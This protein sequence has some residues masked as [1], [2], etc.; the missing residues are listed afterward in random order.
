MK[1]QKYNSN[2]TSENV[3]VMRWDSTTVKITG[4]I[5]YNGDVYRTE[6]IETLFN[7]FADNINDVSSDDTTLQ[8]YLDKLIKT[9]NNIGIYRMLEGFKYDE[10]R[11]YNGKMVLLQTKKINTSYTVWMPKTIDYKFIKRDYY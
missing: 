2:S 7:A 3:K 5:S 4:E 10:L 8:F 1:D 6:D 9:I 11:L